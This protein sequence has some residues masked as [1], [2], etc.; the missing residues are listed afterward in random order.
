MFRVPG[1]VQGSEL[2]GRPSSASRHMLVIQ[3]R[4]LF[5]ASGACHGHRCNIPETLNPVSRRPLGLGKN[6]SPG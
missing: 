3:S 4:D 5:M 2:L 1:F 6:C